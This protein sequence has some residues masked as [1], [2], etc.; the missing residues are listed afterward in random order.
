MNGVYAVALGA[1]LAFAAPAQASPPDAPTADEIRRLRAE[2]EELRARVGEGERD[3]ADGV[4]FGQDVVVPAG[5]EVDEA[6][7]FGGTVRIDGHVRGDATSFGGDVVIGPEGYVE[8]DAVSF[9]GTLEVEDGGRI[10]GDRVSFAAPPIAAHAG[11]LP[12]DAP[13][14]GVSWPGA[15]WDWVVHR[16]V[17]ALTLGGASVLAIGLFPRR[18]SRVASAL[19]EH[20]LRAGFV[21]V[22][23]SGFAA[24]FAGLFTIL[25]LGLG[26]PVS[27]FVVAVIGAAWLLGFVAL[28]QL[29]GDR[30]PMAD[31]THG[32][33][34][35]LL[36][37]VLLLSSVGSLSWLGW[38][39][40]AG[41]G[42][43]AVG[44]SLTSRFGGV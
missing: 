19:E 3:G 7:S 10:D 34:A 16:V 36:I 24:I 9:G 44:G 13:P 6:T 42:L 1:T 22:F 38:A 40:V 31:K 17:A 28:C 23:G 4:G 11:P 15:L 35:A 39:V 26:I 41:V 25:T 18:I 8:G 14:R 20:P 5:E 2:V 43:V 12:V 30:L 37:G 21:G 33:W 27:A 32:R 29:I